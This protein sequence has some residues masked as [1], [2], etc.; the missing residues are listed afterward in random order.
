[1]ADKNQLIADTQALLENA[2]KDTGKQLAGSAL[3]IANYTIEQ[4]QELS[5]LAGD[6]NFQDAVI[7][8]RDNVALKAGISAVN[9][10]DAVDAKV[11][12]IIQTAITFAARAIAA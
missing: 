6:P 3:D 8:A 12:A 9:S 2:L 11:V 5:A 7:A 1:M 10:G 4:A